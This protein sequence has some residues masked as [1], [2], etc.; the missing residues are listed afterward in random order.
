MGWTDVARRQAGVIS[1]AQLLALGLTRG[2]IDRLC[3]TGRFETVG[4]AGVYRVAG[5]PDV[6]QA[7]AWVAVLATGAP[8]SFASAA[9]VWGLIVPDDGLI[10]I[11]RRERR[12]IDWPSGVRVH[13]VRLVD[14]A[15]TQRVGLP[16]TTLEETVLDCAATLPRLHA[17]VLVDRCVQQ[18]LLDRAA[19]ERR[20]RDQPGRWGNRQLRAL[21]DTFGDGAAAESERRLHDLLRSRGISGWVPNYSVRISGRRLVLDVAF[22]TARLAIEVDGYAYHSAAD[23]FQADRT[24]QN[25][26]MAAGWRVLRFTWADLEGRPAYVIAQITALLAA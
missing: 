2:Q 23:R 26:L 4:V 13:R 24:K 16:V 10:H 12:R 22:P 1:R 20:L 17:R 9:R 5:A 3:R 7:A 11:T 25:L 8:L 6:E 14:D 15:V 19:V 18:R 21:L